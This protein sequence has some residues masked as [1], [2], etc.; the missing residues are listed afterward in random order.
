MIRMEARRETH[1]S[2]LKKSCTFTARGNAMGYCTVRLRVLRVLGLE[3]VK[4]PAT[5]LI[6]PDSRQCRSWTRHEQIKTHIEVRI[7]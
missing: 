4:Y 7:S 3:D 5:I 1:Q 6:C 2:F